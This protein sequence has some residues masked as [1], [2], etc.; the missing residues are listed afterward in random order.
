ME[1][2]ERRHLFRFDSPPSIRSSA[3]SALRFPKDL[4]AA[5]RPPCQPGRPFKIEAYVSRILHF[6]IVSMDAAANSH[7]APLACLPASDSFRRR[8]RSGAGTASRQLQHIRL[9]RAATSGNRAC[10]S[11]R[12]RSRAG[13]RRRLRARRSDGNRCC[14]KR[15][16]RCRSR[17]ERRAVRLEHV[18]RD[19]VHVET[20]GEQVVLIFAAETRRFIAVSPHG[21]GGAEVRQHRHQV[22]GAFMVV[23]HVVIFAVN[24]AVDRVDEAVAFAA[25]G[26]AGRTSS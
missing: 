3:M 19:F 13:C 23:D 9:G 2:H 4:A 18:P 16:N 17:L 1:S 8:V 12:Y 15:G 10:T 20:A 14:R 5:I 6:M 25:A 24:A 21:G 11:R 7:L 26:D 22:A